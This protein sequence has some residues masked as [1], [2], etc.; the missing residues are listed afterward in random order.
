MTAWGGRGGTWPG[1]RAAPRAPPYRAR[2][3]GA[4]TG[5][6]G[7]AGHGR[8]P[9]EVRCQLPQAAAPG[10]RGARISRLPAAARG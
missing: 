2:E 6:L 7:G 10:T 9:A 5:R 1:A 4:R 8:R 3:V